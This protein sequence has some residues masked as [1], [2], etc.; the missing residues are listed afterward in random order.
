MYQKAGVVG[1]GL[2]VLPE[3]GGAVVFLLLA[4]FTLIVA[5]GSLLRMIPKREE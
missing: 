2:M 5:G 1:A 4:G 3:T